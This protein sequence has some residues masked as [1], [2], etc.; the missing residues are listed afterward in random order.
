MNQI[1]FVSE[2]K[3]KS[4]K[5]KK[6]DKHATFGNIQKKAEYCF[7]H[8]ENGMIDVIHKR[9][10]YLGCTKIPS[11]AFENSSPEFCAEHRETGM[12]FT[13]TNKLCIYE[14]C[15]KRAYFGLSGHKPQYCREHKKEEMAD[16]IS[17]KCKHESLY[18]FY[19]EFNINKQE[20]QEID[21]YNHQILY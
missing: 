2:T 4:R 1:T 15:S 9:C 7:E 13:N 10:K 21:Y 16:V 19:D 17:K 5:C 20:I 6:C 11:Y 14:N 8:K 12:I 18:L 3:I